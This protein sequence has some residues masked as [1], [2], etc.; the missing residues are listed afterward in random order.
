MIS[1]LISITPPYYWT[2]G[3]WRICPTPGFRLFFTCPTTSSAE[4]KYW[5]WRIPCS[6]M[7]SFITKETTKPWAFLQTWKLVFC[8]GHTFTHRSLN[9]IYCRDNCVMFNS[10]LHSILRPIRL[11]HACVCE[12][13]WFLWFLLLLTYDGLVSTSVLTFPWIPQLVLRVLTYRRCD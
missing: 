5:S 13:T 2:V 3:L 9:L 8:M 10:S 12:Y 4:S 11:T 7:Q 1:W 6:S